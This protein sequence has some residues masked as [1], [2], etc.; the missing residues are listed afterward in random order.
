MNKNGYESINTVI[1]KNYKALSSQ[2][3]VKEIEAGAF[4]RC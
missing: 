2:E 1:E 4:I 3:F